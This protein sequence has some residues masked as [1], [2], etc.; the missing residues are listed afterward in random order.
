MIGL[1]RTGKRCLTLFF[2]TALIGCTTTSLLPATPAPGGV[3]LSGRL[4][5]KVEP[6]PLSTET[7]SQSVTAQFELEGRPDDGILSLSTP[8]GTLMAQAR[9]IDNRAE[10]TGPD[11]KRKTGSL[12]AL[13]HEA[14]GQSIPVGALMNWLQ[15]RPAPDAPSA[16]LPEPDFGFMQI[17][18]NINLNRW[19][20][21]IITATRDG[22]D[23][24]EVRVKLDPGSMP[25]GASPQP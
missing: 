21:R 23:R 14:L 17:G 19:N 9:W 1:I 10:L 16:Q 6:G 8:L 3:S 12:D 24:I 25:A 18:W 22:V 5:I 15:G 13:T 20:D 2:A 4:S 7:R 11:G